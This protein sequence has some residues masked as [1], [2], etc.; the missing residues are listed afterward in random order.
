MKRWLERWHQHQEQIR[1]GLHNS[2]VHQLLGERIFHNHIWALDRTGVAGGLSLGL[3]IAFTPTI[4]FQMA[5]AALGAVFLSVNLP[6][7]VA[8]CW[9][10]NPVTALPVYLAARNLGKTLLA[11]TGLVEALVE[12]FGFQGPMGIFLIQSLYLWSGALVFSCVAALLGY[13]V[14][15]ALW[16]RLHRWKQARRSAQP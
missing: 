8:A 12:L 14:G 2:Y 15:L 3:F 7:S 4:P 10:T 13:L 9:V 6:L 1:A 11:D 16:E 5:L